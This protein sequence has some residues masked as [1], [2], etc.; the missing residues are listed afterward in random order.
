LQTRRQAT[1]DTQSTPIRTTG[2][3]RCIIWITNMTSLTLNFSRRMSFWESLDLT[4]WTQIISWAVL[5]IMELM[6]PSV[7]LEESHIQA[8][9]ECQDQLGPPCS[10]SWQIIRMLRWRS[11]KLSSN[12]MWPS[13]IRSSIIAMVNQELTHWTAWFS[14]S[15]Q[16]ISQ[17]SLKD[18]KLSRTLQVIPNL[19]KMTVSHSCFS[20]EVLIKLSALPHTSQQLLLSTAIRLTSQHSFKPL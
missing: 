3:Q 12:F 7:R 19:Q 2:T 20:Q 4:M 5:V 18:G 17:L 14:V 1:S 15:S 8:S 6:E 13:R 11:F 10:S 9:T 16:T